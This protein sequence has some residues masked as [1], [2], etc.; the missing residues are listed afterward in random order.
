MIFTKPLS[1][2]EIKKKLNNEDVITIISCQACARASG[3]GG[4]EKMKELALNLRSDGFNVKDG[5]TINAVCTPKVIQAKLDKKVNTVITMSCSAGAANA[6]NMLAVNKVVGTSTDIG[7]M[8]VNTKEKVLK[9]AMPYESSKDEKNKEYQM[10]SG[11][12]V[13]SNDDKNKVEV[14]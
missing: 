2:D 5:Y 8:S 6:S 9:V 7:L 4:E 12:A 11:K 3:S 10:F 1:Y 13:K 14:E